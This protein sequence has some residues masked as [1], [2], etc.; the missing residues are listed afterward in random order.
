MAG[1]FLT[2]GVQQWRDRAMF[3]AVVEGYA[4]LPRPLVAPF[5]TLLPLAEIATGLLLLWPASG[6]AGAFAG[7]GILGGVS[8]GVVINLLRGR[9]DIDCGCGGASGD[10]TLSWA[11]VA[12]NGVLGCFLGLG[13]LQASPRALA[14]LDVG[15]ALCAGLAALGL[16]AASNQLLANAPRLQALR[17][18]LA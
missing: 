15:V 3:A 6:D 11:L 10:Q 18:G 16:Y 9:R 8:S 2:G 1:V 5:A 4:L 13:A 17:D 14:A 7:L 12:R